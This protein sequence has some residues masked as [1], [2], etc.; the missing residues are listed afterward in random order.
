MAYIRKTRD[1]WDIE[2]NS[3]FGDGWEIVSS[4]TSLRLARE[5]LKDYRS[6][7]PELPV[8]A[9]KHRERIVPDASCK[10]RNW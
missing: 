6:N 4:C 7:Q 8:R 1:Y 9:R 10:V 5:E 2:Q 3:G